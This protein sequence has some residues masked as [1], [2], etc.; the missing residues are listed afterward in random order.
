[1]NQEQ[2]LQLMDDGRLQL[3]ITQTMPNLPTGGGAV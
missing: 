3:H 2:V 1:V